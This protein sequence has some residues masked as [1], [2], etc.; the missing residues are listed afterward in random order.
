MAVD[1]PLVDH[2]RLRYVRSVRCRMIPHMASYVRLDGCS[3]F[4]A[5][6]A[7]A[8]ESCWSIQCSSRCGYVISAV[9]GCVKTYYS[10]APRHVQSTRQ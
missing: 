8:T 6:L 4:R 2:G 9:I 7:G 3:R 10:E 5:A 1:L